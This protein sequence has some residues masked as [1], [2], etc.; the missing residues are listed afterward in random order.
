MALKRLENTEKRIA[1]NREVA[2]CM[3]G[4]SI[5]MLKR[6]MY[7]KLARNSVVLPRFPVIRSERE[8]T[9]VCI[10]F[11]ASTKQDR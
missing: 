9:Q 7:L 3:K 11:D 6:K 10:V 5:Y 2:N 4:Q 8:T 1:R